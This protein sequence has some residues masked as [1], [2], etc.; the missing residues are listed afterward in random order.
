MFS[1][2]LLWIGAFLGIFL[3]WRWTPALVIV[4]LVWT[5]VLLKLHMSSALPLN[6]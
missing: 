3:K 4:T 2:F 1:M 5:L 6:F